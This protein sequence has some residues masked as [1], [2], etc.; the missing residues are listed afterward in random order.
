MINE[1][2]RVE[3]Q[4]A[5]NLLAMQFKNSHESLQEQMKQI[6]EDSRSLLLSTSSIQSDL[7]LLTQTVQYLAD[8]Q[9][10]H[11]RRVSQHNKDINSLM[12]EFASIRDSIK[13]I[14]TIQGDLVRDFNN[15]RPLIEYVYK[16]KE[17]REQRKDSFWDGIASGAA[18][19][20]MK[21]LQFLI[22][23]SLAVLLTSEHN[24]L[25]PTKPDKPDKPENIQP[26]N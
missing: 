14:Q 21:A 9:G 15:A 25:L 5:L 1:E 2:G 24:P 13:E 12:G 26:A 4:L 22:V 18:D 8:T 11:E 3:N 19:M 16:E 7:R 10:D 6:A 23:G 20:V 17:D